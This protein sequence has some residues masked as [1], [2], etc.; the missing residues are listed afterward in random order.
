M[1]TSTILHKQIRVAKFNKKLAAKLVKHDM[2]LDPEEERSKRRIPELAHLNVYKFRGEIITSE[3]EREQALNYIESLFENDNAN[4]DSTTY[5]KTKHKLKK[6]I[7][8]DKC[9]EDEKSLFTKLLTATEE[10]K[11]T[12]IKPDVAIQKLEKCGKVSRFNDKKKAIEKLIELHNQRKE[13]NIDQTSQLN[14]ALVSVI[15]K[16]PNHNKHDLS[17]EEQEKIITDYYKNN[18]PDYEIVLSILHKDETDHHVHLTIDAKNRT[19]QQY[20]F[21]QNQYQYIK[22]K[23]GLT[24]YP[25]LYSKLDTQQLVRV[26]E[27]LQTDFYN[28]INEQQ[29]KV[30]FKKKEYESPEQKQ[31]E[32]NIIKQDTSKP[33][34]DREYNT[35][36]YLQ[37]LNNKERKRIEE[38]I[39]HREKLEIHNTILEKKEQVLQ[40]RIKA[41][42]KD[43]ID[44]A[45]LYAVDTMKESLDVLRD[46]F[47]KIHQ[48][49]AETA[50]ETKNQA[51][52]I[53]PSE[54]KRN[55]V[56]RAYRR[57]IAPKKI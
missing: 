50:L 11:A 6:W 10:R 51:V 4:F 24:D 40:G 49:N 33:I 26:G 54:D 19:N 13:L 43:A 36:N 39:E 3:E 17:A 57:S 46:R 55:D 38:V 45:T 56:E 53:Q 44:A 29:Q 5:R 41:L 34:A 14:T 21:V 37:M 35:A 25:E 32:R 28:H 9:S 15:L 1:R 42:I 2:L 47:R 20:D 23:A 31:T 30:L 22:Q 48:I 18:F 7:E 27:E 12:T 8:S 16:I 52:D